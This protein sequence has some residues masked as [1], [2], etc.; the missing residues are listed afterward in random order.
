[1]DE[2]SVFQDYLM[3]EYTK[4]SERLHRWRPS[5][6]EFARYLGVSPVSLN[7]W[8]LGSR[9]PDL[10]NAIRLAERL[11]PRVYDILGLPHVAVLNDPMLKFVF[12]SWEVL[13]NDA[14]RSILDIVERKAGGHP[15]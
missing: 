4:W 15:E 2:T 3:G 5:L 7:H 11:G 8:L 13:D 10:Q 12:Q 6:N 14:R 1:M 9:V